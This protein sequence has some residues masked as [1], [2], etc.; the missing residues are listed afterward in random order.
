MPL[1]L[2]LQ[3]EQRS[4][5]RVFVQVEL[6]QPEAP[7]HVNGAAVELR[8]GRGVLLSP[9]M[10]LPIA[11][12]LVGHLTTRIELRAQQTIPQGAKVYGIVF[13]DGGQTEASIPA[14]PCTDLEA[15]VRGRRNLGYGQTHEW[16]SLS[17]REEDNLAHYFPWAVTLDVADDDDE[18]L[19]EVHDPITD[20]VVS[21]LGLD[22]DSA[23]LL[24]SLLDDDPSEVD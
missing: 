4:P 10:I 13:W 12:N 23:D 17:E 16:Q 2:S 11:G 19:A 20:E 5:D 22:D 7:I 6:T 18:S 14:D 8:G 1:T 3:I 15:H 21:A 9:R 24:R